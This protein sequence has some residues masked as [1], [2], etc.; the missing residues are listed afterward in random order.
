MDGSACSLEPHRPK[1]FYNMPRPKLTP[2]AVLAGL[3]VPEGDS[4]RKAVFAVIESEV[5]EAMKEVAVKCG[6]PE[7]VLRGAAGH[8]SGLLHIQD[9][10]A[11]AY[12]KAGASGPKERAAKP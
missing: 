12:E 10:L 6:E 1:G 11:H 3:R 2:E 7:H 9:L 8:L 4:Q 5:T